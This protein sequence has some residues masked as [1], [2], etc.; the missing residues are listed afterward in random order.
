MSD[1]LPAEEREI[2]TRRA[3]EFKRLNFTETEADL[4][5]ASEA[6]PDEAAALLSRGCPH[7]LAV[8][9]LH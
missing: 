7:K 2:H 3:A 1:E 6:N 8:A 4:L 5:A 9:I